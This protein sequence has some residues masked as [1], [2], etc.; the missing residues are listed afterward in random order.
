MLRHHHQGSGTL[1]VLLVMLLAATVM[2]LLLSRA[3]VFEQRAA[4][5]QWRATLAF[6]AA[7][8]GRHWALA[9]LNHDHGVDDSCSAATT[10]ARP[11]LRER[12]LEHDPAA[13]GWRPTGVQPACTLR[14]DAAAGASLACTCP[15]GGAAAAPALADAAAAGASSAV[16]PAAFSV[17]LQAGPVAGSLL[18]RTRGCVGL[19]CDDGADAQAVV[20]VGLALVRGAPGHTSAAVVAAGPV[21]LAGA[22][23]I[24]NSHAAAGGLAVDSGG[25]L[26]AESGVRLLGPPGSSG[27]ATPPVIAANPRWAGLTGDSFFRA[28]FGQARTRHASLPTLTRLACPC[29]AAAVD[30]ALARG[31]RALLLDGDLDASSAGTTPWGSATRPVLLIVDGAARVSGALQLTGLLHARSLAWN[32]LDAATT[33]QPGLLRGALLSEGAVVLNGAITVVHDPQVLTRAAH[34]AAVYAPV[35]GSWRDF[36][37]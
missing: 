32:H 3:L 27:A 16:Q 1:A 34:A 10:G 11:S 18:L 33:N 9:G 2:L 35:P 8:A 31:A 17:A 22:V 36:G 24:V 14:A 19:R 15:A 29:D 25:A 12:L 13:A 30:A 21:T 37:D 26:S 7:E 5:L 23:S 6:E 20:Q 4:A 28:H